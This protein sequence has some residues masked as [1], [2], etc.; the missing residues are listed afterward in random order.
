MAPLLYGALLVVAL[1]GQALPPPEVD[2]PYREYQ[3]AVEAYRHCDD[4]RAL[5]FVTTQDVS[6]AVAGIPRQDETPVTGGR[7]PW[8]S[9]ALAAAMLLHERAAEVVPEAAVKHRWLA[10]D[11][12]DRLLASPPEG[13][14]REAALALAVVELQF[15]GNIA[16]LV[17]MLSRLP[18]D[19]R[20]HPLFLLA[21]GSLH[22]LL[23][24]PL[25]SL[26]D[27]PWRHSREIG[28]RPDGWGGMLIRIANGSKRANRDAAV[29]AYRHVLTV[30]PLDVEARIRLAYLL[31][32]DGQQSEAELVLAA[33]PALARRPAPL[34]YFDA[35]VRARAAERQSHLD[36]AIA[37]YTE[38]RRFEPDAQTPV[39]G[40]ARVRLL[41]GRA[42]QAR[43]IIAR[44]LP[45]PSTPDADP[46]WLYHFGQTW[47]HPELLSNIERLVRPCA[48]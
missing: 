39:I 7:A 15:D 19:L 27:T 9:L 38:A 3:D 28:R 32:E 17:Y 8:S 41:Q 47:R 18:E 34:P 24:T 31:V 30:D 46:W 20:N 22:E 11:L 33:M 43:E 13:A 5:S 23:S 10:A 29:R 1:G 40:L 2:R 45:R 37:H 26:R 12:R 4:A 35:L 16:E 6:A 36:R 42:S 21:I 48:P 44:E 14:L 25:A